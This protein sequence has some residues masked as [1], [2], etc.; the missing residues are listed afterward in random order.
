MNKKE[1]E[2]VLDYINFFIYIV[3]MDR[4][5][6]CLK[7]GQ[8]IEDEKLKHILEGDVKILKRRRKDN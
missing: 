8:N 7:D 5:E 1:E 6:Y 3:E 2:Y 4:E